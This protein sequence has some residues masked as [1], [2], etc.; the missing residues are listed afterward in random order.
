MFYLEQNHAETGEGCSCFIIFFSSLTLC[1]M[2]QASLDHESLVLYL[3]FDEGEGYAAKDGSKYGHN[4][5]LI[6]NNCS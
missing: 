6:N 3:S 2:V 4:G 5:T 1:L